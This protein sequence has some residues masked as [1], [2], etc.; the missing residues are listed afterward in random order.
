M[1]NDHTSILLKR[2]R[3]V[4]WPIPFLRLFRAAQCHLRLEAGAGAA[5]AEGSALLLALARVAWDGAIQRSGGR[6]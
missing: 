5:P 6:S 2:C 4:P 1:T 3:L